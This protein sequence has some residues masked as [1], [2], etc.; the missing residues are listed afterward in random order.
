MNPIELL[1]IVTPTGVDKVQLAAADEN[2]E[3]A[4]L[5]LYQKLIHEIQLFT[6]RV[7]KILTA[8]K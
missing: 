6:K 4:G 3:I 2:G 1:I 8:E 5:E 7:N